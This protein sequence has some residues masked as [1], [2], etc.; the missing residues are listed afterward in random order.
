MENLF[1]ICSLLKGDC[2]SVAF[3]RP[4]PS[5]YLCGTKDGSIIIHRLE[6]EQESKGSA[7]CAA[8]ANVNELKLESKGGFVLAIKWNDSWK[9]HGSHDGIYSKVKNL[10]AVSCSS[11]KVFIFDIENRKLLHNLNGLF[12]FH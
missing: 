11:G 5:H 10:V 1:I 9:K 8:L 3:S 7:S 2:F 6:Q 12:A 4:E